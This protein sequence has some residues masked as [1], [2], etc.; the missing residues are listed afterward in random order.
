MT[1][2]K[3][4]SGTQ[5]IIDT[6][7]PDYAE[8]FPVLE[9]DQSTEYSYETV[10]F[11]AHQYPI[12]QHE[13][14]SHLFKHKQFNNLT[15]HPAWDLAAGN[16]M[17]WTLEKLKE[18]GFEHKV[19]PVISWYI[20]YQKDGWQSMHTH[21][22]NCI[23]QIIYMDD[24]PHIKEDSAPKESG[25]G[26]MYVAMGGD[27]PVYKSFVSRPGRC[28]LMTGDVLHGVYPV[29]SVPRRSIIVDYLIIT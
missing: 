27:K 19:I 17:V 23:T 12:W 9:V 28:I 6:T 18:H 3:L 5:W 24:T 25:Y 1:D 14:M 15:P 29:K 26:A 16:L 20:D 13:N 8:F 10:A 2:T 7:Y 11:G 21:D 4:A 22:N